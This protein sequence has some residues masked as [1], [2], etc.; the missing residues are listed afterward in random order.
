MEL[1]ALFM[2]SKISQP[3]KARVICCLL[4]M[5]SSEGGKKKVGEPHE[6]RNGTS[7]VEEGYWRGKRGDPGET[8]QI[9]SSA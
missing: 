4:F 7:R 8:D 6:N 3:Q 9:M 1:G 5:V 2:L